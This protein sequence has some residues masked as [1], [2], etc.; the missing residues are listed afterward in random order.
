MKKVFVTLLSYH[1]QHFHLRLYGEIL[2]LLIVLLVF[3]YTLD[4]ED[5]YIDSFRGSWIRVVW[6]FLYQGV[7][8]LLTGWML[9]RHHKSEKWFTSPQFWVLF[10][11][12]FLILS[13]DR[14]FF[15]GDAVRSF[16]PGSTIRIWYRCINWV[17][18]FLTVAIPLML[19]Y[20]LAEKNKLHR[21][22]GFQIGK[23]DAKP[24]LYLLLIAGVFIGIGSF[25]GD[26]QSYYPRYRISA[27]QEFARY[28]DIPQ[29][30][31]LFL[32]ETSYASN[33]VTVEL[34]FRGFLIYAFVRYFGTYA[35]LPMVVSY[36]VLHFGKPLTE[37]LSSIIGGYALGI[38]ALNN[39][40][41][42]GGVIIHVGVAW[43]MEL[44]GFLQ[45]VVQ[46]S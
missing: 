7:P 8:F 19:L 6:Y 3:N 36:C 31:P 17:S 5:S 33:F 21:W 37:S 22:Y 10:V 32:F 23:F 26:L 15:L 43:L 30:I 13:F 18:S 16:L 24:Y 41:I 20:E 4:F 1:K 27:G 25:F 40:N 2:V 12:G 35:V 34:F 46:H 9:Y 44:F 45:K 38:L 11:I 28:Y 39:R 14:S 42:W 29:F